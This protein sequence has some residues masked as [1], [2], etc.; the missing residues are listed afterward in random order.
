M[1]IGRCDVFHTWDWNQ[2][3]TSQAKTVTTIHDFV[4]VLFPETQ[5]PKTIKNFR[6]KMNLAVKYCHRFI[7]VSQ[8]TQKD[9]QKLFPQIDHQKVVVIS[10]AASDKYEKF[11]KLSANQKATKTK[12]ITKIYDLKKYFLVQGTREPRKNLPRIIDA[13]NQFKKENPQSKFELAITGKYG[14]GQDIKSTQN[15]FIKIL[16]YIPEKDIVAIH[17]A[18]VCLLYPSLYEGFGLPILQAFKVGIPVITS[19]TSSI[20]EVAGLAAILVNPHSTEEIKNAIT[21]IASSS[22]L[23]QRLI[24][25]GLT[26]AK[27]FSWDKTARETL[28]VYTSLC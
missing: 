18:A 16:G 1:F 7:C 9:L 14:W 25:K 21:K 5:H 26:Q 11:N 17:A 23:R 28:K 10:E 8:N 3:P 2:P 15:S 12:Y 27:K 6:L 20:P 24:A 22:S 4:P 13:F 19:R